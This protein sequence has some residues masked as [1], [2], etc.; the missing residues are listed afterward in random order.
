MRTI[1]ILT[2]AAAALPAAQLDDFV[3]EALAGNPA[4]L[5]ARKRWEASRQ[6]PVQESAMPDP[7]VAFGYASNGGPL[8]GQGLGTNPTSNVGVMVSQELPS[9]GKRKLRADVARK[10]ADAEYAQYLAAQLSVRSRVVQAY[11]RLHHAYAAQEILVHGK[12]LV[13]DMIRVSEAR[14]AAGQAAQ[15]DILKAQVQLS[16]LEAR[17]IQLGLDRA[18]AEAE[19]N[20][21]LNRKA[22][23]PLPRPDDA[24]SAPLTSTAEEWLAKALHSSPDL[25]REQAMIER[26]RLAIDLARR[27]FQTDYKVS[28]G[29]YNTMGMP[30]MFEFRVEVP[31]HLHTAQK[32]APA[33]GEQILRLSEARQNFEAAD[34]NLEFRVRDAFAAAQTAWR[35]M[36]LYS[37]T[38]LPQTELTIESSLASYETGGA[39]FNSVLANV[40]SKVETDER[41]HEQK[42]MYALALARLDELA[43]VLP[44]EAQ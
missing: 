13:S 4:I 5:A 25:R 1:L 19:L 26:G 34:R 35:L 40:I 37:D 16:V 18:S 3:R 27:D 11:H 39:D 38:I 41:Y 33:V 17:L 23:G 20:A 14:Y 31:L 8:P 36:K 29:Y 44:Q 12:Q 24:E 21:L 6:R 43:G 15:Q 22:D 9:A 10:E 32:Q 30:S 28:A 7:M 42:M 2:M